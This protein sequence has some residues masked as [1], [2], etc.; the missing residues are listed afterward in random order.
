MQIF[1]PKQVAQGSL[2]H[3]LSSEAPEK[4]PWYIPQCWHESS[5]ASNDACFF[6]SFTGI[7]MSSKLFTL[8]AHLRFMKDKAHEFK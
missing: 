8:L 6:I 5:Y 3:M 7:S 2:H 4:D 1:C